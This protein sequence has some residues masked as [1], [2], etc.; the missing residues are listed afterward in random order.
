[1]NDIDEIMKMY[2]TDLGK[3]LITRV[4]KIA[5]NMKEDFVSAVIVAK[6]H[7]YLE[8]AMVNYAVSEQMYLFLQ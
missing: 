7:F 5:L 4:I 8:D 2:K 1:M 3:R 6:Y